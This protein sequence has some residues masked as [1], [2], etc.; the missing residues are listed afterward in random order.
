M[1]SMER[2]LSA[3]T[4]TSCPISC[5]V[6][7]CAFRA[8]AP[9]N[10]SNVQVSLCEVLA[11]MARSMLLSVTFSVN[12]LWQNEVCSSL[13]WSAQV[14][15]AVFQGTKRVLRMLRE[16]ERDSCAPGYNSFWSWINRA[17]MT[18]PCLH[19]TGAKGCTW[20]FF[21]FYLCVWSMD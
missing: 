2:V 1:P 17:G 13:S 9:H 19:A 3:I 14:C 8:L 12:I 21:G 15:P 5:R 4:G 11:G 6:A 7:Q 10:R 18:H 16:R 20:G